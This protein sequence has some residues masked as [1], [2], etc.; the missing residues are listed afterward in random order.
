MHIC[1]L[2]CKYRLYFYKQAAMNI[3][4]EKD[5]NPAEPN[6]YIR[7]Y[8]KDFATLSGKKLPSELS[9][10]ENRYEPPEKPQRRK[11]ELLESQSFQRPDE[12]LQVSSLDTD[13]H[14]AD[15]STLQKEAEG[16]ND[17]QLSEVTPPSSGPATPAPIDLPEIAPGEIV[18][19]TG[20]FGFHHK[21][22]KESDSIEN[23]ESDFAHAY[24][25]PLTAFGE[26]PSTLTED[27]E[28]EAILARLKARLAAQQPAPIAVQEVTLPPAPIAEIQPITP[29]VETVSLPVA[30]PIPEPSPFH[31]FSSDFSDRID[32][33][34]ASTFSVLAAEKDA[35]PKRKPASRRK[36]TIILPITIAILLIA[37]GGGGAYV[38]YT[39]MK[40]DAPVAIIPTSS[41][42][43]SSNAQVTLSGY[44][45][46]LQQ[47]VQQQ[48]EK[49]I[50]ANSI[51]TVSI[52]SS[53]STDASS[54]DQQ[55]GIFSALQLPAPDILLRNVSPESTVGIIN[56]S[57]QTTVFFVLRADSYERT[58]AG[59]LAWEPTMLQ[60]LGTF[61]SLYP[62][63]QSVTS[64]TASSTS[65]SSTPIVSSYSEQPQSTG[66]FV[67]EVV[68][69]HDA[70]ALK[71]T[72]GNTLIVYGYSDKQ[73]LII[74]RDESAFTQ[75]LGR[76]TSN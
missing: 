15:L 25:S 27:T 44:G 9:G 30:S 2:G 46:S 22:K 32:Q 37:V 24:K 56:D 51:T 6:P 21:E 12:S 1:F 20:W 75:V 59:M 31:S 69:N 13:I 70:R 48:T 34:K 26:A 74:A 76:L 64:G 28:R 53:A 57:T 68:D 73:T 72:A 3:E 47:S 14:T 49:A 41:S 11:H 40:S 29:R 65:A 61:Y 55:A 23:S 4:P 67:D 43:V 62:A 63:S 58:F 54:T 39:Y 7:T 52:N 10:S 50:T 71:D 5:N 19:K 8:A 60:D 45:T 16:I 35:A 17:A 33:Q 42:L 36:S 38:A 66:Q 18:H